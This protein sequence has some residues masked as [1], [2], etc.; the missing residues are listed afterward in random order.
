[1]LTIQARAG[2]DI[3]LGRQGENYARRVAFDFSD[4]AAVYGF[5]V[6]RLLFQR[7]ADSAP[8]PVTLSVET[9]TE[10]VQARA[11]WDVSAT[12]TEHAG[13]G[14]AELR[15]YAGETLVKSEVFRASVAPA[16]VTPETPP[17]PPGSNW[18]EGILDAASRAERAAM[19]AALATANIE[20]V[21]VRAVTLEPGSPASVSAASENGVRTMT[22]SIPAGTPG[23]DGTDGRDGTNGTNGV[24]GTDGADG[25]SVTGIETVS[26]T[27]LSGGENT[28]RLVL[29]NGEKLPFSVRNGAKGDK[30]DPFTIAASYA[31][32]NAMTADFS[33]ANIPE[34][35]FVVISSSPEDP[36]N[37]EL[38]HKGGAAW[39]LVTD[40]SGAQGLTGPPG[41]GIDYVEENTNS[42]GDTLVTLHFT[43]SNVQPFPF[44]V[45]RGLPGQNGANGARGEKG[46]DGEKGDKGDDATINGVN[47]LTIQAGNNNIHFSQ[48]G[49]V[50]SISS[51]NT[52]YAPAVSGG[53]D[54]LMTG[55]D[56]AKLDGIALPAGGV[57]LPVILA[58]PSVANFTS[59]AAGRPLRIAAN[60]S[61]IQSG[62]PSPSS[63]R[64]ITGRSSITIARTAKNFYPIQNAVKTYLGVT[65]TVENGLL[66]INGTLSTSGQQW[67]N[68]NA[69]SAR[70]ITFQRGTY[71]QSL[72][73]ISGT[74]S[75]GAT[76][77]LRNFSTSYTSYVSVNNDNRTRSI[78]FSVT[79]PMTVGGIGDF[80]IHPGTYNNVKIQ[81][82]LELSGA[83]TDFE[84]IQYEAAAFTFPSS[85][86]T[87][88]GGTLDVARGLLSVTYGQIASYNGETLPGAW[89]SSM[90]VYTPGGTPTT[91][92]QVVY[93]LAAPLTY[94]LAP[95][96]LVTLAGTNNV[97]AD[98]GNVTVTHWPGTGTPVEPVD[99]G[100]ETAWK[101]SVL[102]R[103]AALE[104]GS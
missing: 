7:S 28:Y 53:A 31:S 37:A 85:I 62:T 67:M 45:H 23:R 88:Y 8:Y 32:Y 49:S 19:D 63:P 39:E 98:R 24:N 34:G 1:M 92:A 43:D 46:D 57:S 6:P 20:N 59:A 66:T 100:A 26:A 73:V 51:D 64:A 56:K 74:M 68:G 83:V 33:N 90:D 29:S 48:S 96:Q 54:G 10:H 76:I 82:Q 30:G 78:P 15:Y 69:I 81:L 38:Y 101:K 35:S 72:R 41:N 27:T 60:M 18:A 89:L 77:T 9:D 14:R 40:L 3:P 86:G 13:T 65:F 12:D 79:A 99:D 4:W 71:T 97:F 80:G 16:L 95:Q 102:D 5:G 84:P 93:E 87:V 58:S 44:T 25:V 94:Q 75:D 21:Q 91:G 103:L 50:L 2:Q 42:A 52:T 47:A 22:F 61:P 11:L 17:P 36:H 55:T 70:G 104:G